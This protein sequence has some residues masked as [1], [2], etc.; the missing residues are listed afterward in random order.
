LKGEAIL[1]GGIDKS[2]KV[3]LTG[4]YELDEGTYE[5]SFNL[6][7]RSFKIQK[8][9]KITWTGEPTDATMDITAVYVANTTAVE[10]VQDQIVAAR[11]DLRYRQRLP[12]EVHLSM[13]GALLKPELTFEIKLPKESTVR[14]DSDIANQ[15][16]MRLNQLKAEPSEL[17]KQ[18]FSLLILNRFT[19]QNPFETAGGGLNPESMA[20]QSVSKI[21]TQQLNNLASDLISGVDINFDV[22]S[23]ED[24]TS[25][26]MQNKTDF[27]VGV[28][29]RLFSERL[30]VT[31]G[32]NIALEGGQQN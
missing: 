2:G 26:K 31:V 18:V 19:S 17:N 21:M 30:N 16:E 25:G 9:S 27:N 13:K 29:K 32:T 24:F 5:L 22:V 3:T 11:T 10:L 20:R 12:F 4:T 28:S 8:G 15:I 1:N 23:S 6:I 7:D 14:I